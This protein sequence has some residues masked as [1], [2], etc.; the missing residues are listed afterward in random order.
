[1]KV[2]IVTAVIFIMSS[3]IQKTDGGPETEDDLDEAA[4]ICCTAV[5]DEEGGICLKKFKGHVT[6]THYYKQIVSEVN[7]GLETLM[8]KYNAE[9]PSATEDEKNNR[10]EYEKKTILAPVTQAMREVNIPQ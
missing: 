7:N 8:E 1:M 6:G 2:S 5:Y 10:K 3:G 9:N 4:G